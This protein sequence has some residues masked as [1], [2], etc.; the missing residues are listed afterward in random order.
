MGGGK[1]WKSSELI[2]LMKPTRHK[3][4]KAPTA[5]PMHAHPSAGRMRCSPIQSNTP[6]P[7]RLG[8]I[9]SEVKNHIPGA[10]HTFVAATATRLPRLVQQ[11][12]SMFLRQPHHRCPKGRLE[13]PVRYARMVY[14]K[15]AS[16]RYER[17][18][19]CHIFKVCTTTTQTGKFMKS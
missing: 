9:T 15:T 8:S 14:I 11:F 4:K 10:K 6:C 18:P 19:R 7:C 17:I 2:V 16:K 1:K 5:T 3:Y 12:V 13:K